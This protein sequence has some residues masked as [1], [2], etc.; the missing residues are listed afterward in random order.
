MV[1]YRDKER[2]EA[3]LLN[4]HLTMSYPGHMTPNNVWNNVDQFKY[5]APAK[6]GQ[7]LKTVEC[8]LKTTYSK[9]ARTEANIYLFANGVI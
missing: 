4:L 1:A 8:R 2:F 9:L 3:E 6:S 5:D 7:N